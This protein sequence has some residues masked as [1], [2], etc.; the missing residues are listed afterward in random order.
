MN[1]L[2]LALLLALAAAAQALAE[3]RIE[4]IEPAHWWAGM[5]NPRLQLL[6][7]GKD[8]ATL[9]PAVADARAA[10]RAVIR[11]SN[12]NYLFIELMVTADAG[13]KASGS[14]TVRFFSTACDATG[15]SSV[16][17]DIE[18]G[19][20]LASL[21]TR[22]VDAWPAL[23]PLAGSLLIAVNYEYSEPTRILVEQLR[24]VDLERPGC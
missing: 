13:R 17:I 24:A 6:V 1:R 21:L 9:E 22:L 7:R 12:P 5:K 14:V 19:E 3:A 4:R 23:G 10:V 15:Q 11:T 18:A 2:V 20:T 16:Q 8:V